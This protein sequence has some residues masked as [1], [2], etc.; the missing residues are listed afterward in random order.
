MAGVYIPI[1][2]SYSNGVVTVVS[3]DGTP[4][5]EIVNSMGSYVYKINEIY[6]KANSPEQLMQG[7][8]MQHYDVNGTIQSY[9]EAPKVDPYQYQKSLFIKPVIKNIIFDGR[10]LAG[11]SL[12]PNEVLFLTL[13][14]E[15]IAMSSYLKGNNPFDNDFYTSNFDFLRDYAEAII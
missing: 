13:F 3:Q 14:G 6:L 15:A 10:T 2:T 9:L 1:V 7:I 11:V 8:T 5:D 4:Y 12:L